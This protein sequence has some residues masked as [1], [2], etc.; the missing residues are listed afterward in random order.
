MN[1]KNLVVLTLVTIIVMADSYKSASAQGYFLSNS[2]EKSASANGPF[3]G[4]KVS[5]DVADEKVKFVYTTDSVEKFGNFVRNHLYLSLQTSGKSD[6][7]ILNLSADNN[8]NPEINFA[9]EVGYKSLKA[10]TF[11]RL[12]PLYDSI[13][14]GNLCWIGFRG[15]YNYSEF[16][17]FYPDSEYYNQVKKELF[18][19][20]NAS[21]SFGIFHKFWGQKK[22]E[23][24]FKK[25]LDAKSDTKNLALNE[26]D[27]LDVFEKINIQKIKS[28]YWIFSGNYKV[29]G[30]NNSDK[31]TKV[32]L[33]DVIFNQPN[34]DTLRTLNREKEV[35]YGSYEKFTQHDFRLD[36]SLIFHTENQELK[37]KEKEPGK[38]CVKCEE[39]KPKYNVLLNAYSR[40]QF[41][42]N[43][44]AQVFAFG[45]GIYFIQNIED[46]FF[47]NKSI[48]NK[49]V[50]VGGIGYEVAFDLN[51]D[52]KPATIPTVKI[53]M[54]F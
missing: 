25:Q 54:A 17:L 15:E 28:K 14:I 23:R 40:L 3:I 18:G 49:T 51:S 7:R 24:S 4:T 34:Q 8:I 21:V 47:R 37:E 50:L 9:T 2:D 52:E 26:Q 33:N 30:G 48:G 12:T 53:G 19:G 39:D 5:I 38:D 46:M 41:K 44:K 16:N 45:F 1:Y 35:L 11:M 42:N 27:T 6:T 10:D 43:Y 22:S 29:S 36:Y 13:V 20:Y 32:K 31:L